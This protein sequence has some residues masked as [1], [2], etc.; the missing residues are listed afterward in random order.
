[1]IV[2]VVAVPHFKSNPLK[3]LKSFLLLVLFLSS[4]HPLESVVFLWP[5]PAAVLSQSVA[6]QSRKHRGRAGWTTTL[7]NVEG[8]VE[9]R[10][11]LRVA[12]EGMST[13]MTT[14]KKK[15]ASFQTM[16]CLSN[17]SFLLGVLSPTLR[18]RKR[19]FP[20]PTQGRTDETLQ[21]QLGGPARAVC[22]GCARCRLG[23]GPDAKELR[24]LNSW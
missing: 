2:V 21:G 3:Y 23:H 13:H 7:N 15:Y 6:R 8:C 4:G 22:G 1:M 16:S 11:E 10:G 9:G 5:S 19:N 20:H 17:Q 24:V 14:V 12:V 18:K